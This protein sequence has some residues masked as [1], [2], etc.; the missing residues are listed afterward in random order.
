MS[1]RPTDEA[2]KKSFIVPTENSNQVDYNSSEDE[3]WDEL[4]EAPK[5]MT[6]SLPEKKDLLEQLPGGNFRIKSEKLK[7]PKS[8]S[9]KRY[10]TK[11]GVHPYDEVEWEKR[12]ASI[13][14]DK[15]EVIF[16]QTDI[17]FP[18]FWSQMA[19]NV[20][21]SKY[22]RGKVGEATKERSLRDL[23]DRVA[24]TIANW[25]LVQNAFG[26]DKDKQI[27]EEELTYLLL[28]QMGSFNSPVWF[29]VGQEE[30][31]QCSACF[32]NSVEDK[33][34]SIM[35]LA[36]TE[37]MLFKYGSGTGTNLS[38]LRAS[39]ENLTT[40]GVASG[41]VS[42]MKGYDAFAGVIKSGGKTRRAAKMVILNVEH[43]DIMEFINCKVKEEKKAW[44][45]IEQGYAGTFD[46]EAYN[47]VFF[48]NSNNSVRVN[49]QFME[50]VVDDESWYTR[51][52]TN[53]EKIGKYRARN[54]LKAISE[55]THVCGD[56]GLQFD[57]M[58]NRWN[59][60]ADTFKINASNPCSEYMF[61]DNSSC[62]LA[63]LNLMKF[64]HEDTE[65]FDPVA[66][67]HAI[68]TFITAQEILVDNASYPRTQIS[69]NSHKYRPLGLGYT[70][71]GA[72]LMSRGLSYD[73]D[74]GRS[75]ASAI[76]SVLTGRA[77]YSSARM[78]KS[79]GPFRAYDEN[80]S[81]F[82]RV[83]N[84][85]REASQKINADYVPADL[86]QHA[87]EVW[88]RTYAAG[89]QYG[90]RNAQATVLAPTGTISFMMDADTTGIEPDLALVKFKKM[91]G[92]G[93]FKIVNN[94]VN[95]AL[96]KLAYT[97]E[98]ISDITAFIQKQAMIEGAPHIKDEH[99]PIFD[100][101]LKPLNGKRY[102]SPLGH[103][104]MM[105]ACQPYISG[106]IS[107]TVNMPQEAT[108][109]EIYEAYLESWK[110][111]LKAIAIYRD[112]SKRTQPLSTSSLDN[113]KAKEKNA[114]VRRKLP[115]E[116][117]A[118]THKFSIEGHEGYLTVGMFEDGTPGEIFLLMS[119]EGSTISGLMDG[120]AT[121]T[122][123]ALQYGVPLDDLVS[124]FSHMRFEPAGFTQNAEIRIA[125]SIY[126]YIFRY[127]ASKFMSKDKQ[128][129]L[130]NHVQP[131]ITSK[132]PTF[133]DAGT[134]SGE[135]QAD[136]TDQMEMPFQS[137]EDAP[138]CPSCGL[139]MVRS[140]TCYLCQNCGTQHGC[141]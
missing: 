137:Q 68:D 61:K 87:T 124:K 22:F 48:Q 84:M 55:A 27:F 140:G 66:F 99:L 8:I 119:K 104:R 123:L 19:T 26:N 94:S 39:E 125:K 78:A 45:L 28:H 77:Y 32:I 127:L 132:S 109:E 100:C 103:I 34:E 31:P 134:E 43:P 135:M 10:F 65:E 85:H 126:D 29:N 46:G 62:N 96:E 105:A 136:S 63:S 112:N 79:F 4:Y 98:E 49:D 51:A 91:V 86:L 14:N 15:G 13:T 80:R 42:F 69:W 95:A 92:G 64:R 74:E 108:V 71:L 82:M 23:I 16:E 90:F 47:S 18:V 73:S 21:V 128:V 57:T 120:F 58:V 141:S 139:I 41:P 110:A 59:P 114:P 12:T 6:S 81:S 37:G 101:A 3:V 107:K 121:M 129:Q 130:G 72:L 44:A 111:G 40:G 93:M 67:S 83:I 11:E 88:D 117:Q 102:I 70:N 122:S 113:D 25:G 76:T 133:G 33:M 2:G 131:T 20:V 38:T 54:V 60:C 24:K 52:V 97:E 7:H 50:K 106:A 5:K 35:D 115:D 75:Y 30:Y 1:T 89:Q 17:D 118:I 56:P 138:L 116:R 36:K 9:W 53:G